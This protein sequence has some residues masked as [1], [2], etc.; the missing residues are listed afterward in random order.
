MSRA[1]AVL[2]LLA[3]TAAAARCKNDGLFVFPTPGS[4][5]PTNSRFLLEGAGKEKARLER[6]SATEDLVLKASD[7]VVVVKLGKTKGVDLWTSEASRVAMVL[8]PTRPLQP[9]K[10]YTLLIDRVLPGFVILNET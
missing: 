6:L 8:T 4:V 2:V 5:I 7:D 9:H 3:A 1:V 10:Q